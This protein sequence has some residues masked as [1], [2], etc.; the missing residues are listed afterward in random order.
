ME[1]KSAI[2]IALIFLLIVGVLFFLPSQYKKFREAKVQ[3]A[4]K[5]IEF[6][7]KDQYFLNLK[8]W[9][10]ELT[11]YESAMKKIDSILPE[12]FEPADIVNFFSRELT[13]NN[14]LLKEFTISQAASLV[15]PEEKDKKPE[16]KKISLDMSVVGTYE[17]FKKLVFKIENSAKLIEI[18]SIEIF[19]PK[20]TTESESSKENKNFFDFQLK[21]GTYSY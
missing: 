17:D 16:I 11:N 15:K 21:M 18:N 13:Q 20:T 8:K 12:K 6:E 4:Q 2:N 1:T 10:K 9:Y 19:S 14:V 5:K 3:F 7:K